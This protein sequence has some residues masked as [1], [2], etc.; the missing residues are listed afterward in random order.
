M[1]TKN[2][3]L[4][5]A[6][7]LT[8]GHGTPLISDISLDIGHGECILLCGPN[9]SGKSTLLRTF[10]GVLPPLSGQLHGADIIL[11]PTRIPKVPGFTLPEFIRTS[12]YRGSTWNG[13]LG[14]TEEEA[15]GTALQML[16][17]ASLADRDIATLSDGEF[18]RGCIATALV[19]ILLS[20]APAAE[21]KQTKDKR[22]GDKQANDKRTEE[23]QTGPH[24]GLILLDEPTAFL[25]VEGRV[26]VLQ[27]LR[28]IVQQTGAS[29]LFSSHD[30]T[31]SLAVA[32]RILGITSEGR[33]L[34]ARS[35][36]N[37]GQVDVRSETGERLVGTRSENGAGQV[38]ARSRAC[39]DLLAACFPALTRTLK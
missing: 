30:L 32:T 15:L 22:T 36:T 17:I 5:T 20:S 21:E 9:G 39:E 33:L 19:R 11:I 7:R 18:Q 34:D 16:D 6:D 23:K 28:N 24:H 4:L 1:T 12:L 2:D 3:L 29:V 8:V 37:E 27:L 25:D 38:G 14:K 10:A 35:E 31:E 13:R 26:Q